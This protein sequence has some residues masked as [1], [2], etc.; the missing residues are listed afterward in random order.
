MHIE[1]PG[2]NGINF[3]FKYL[4]KNNFYD[5]CVLWQ[6]DGWGKR[7]IKQDCKYVGYY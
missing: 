3:V 6:V 7:Q 4:G 2:S 5:G 1:I